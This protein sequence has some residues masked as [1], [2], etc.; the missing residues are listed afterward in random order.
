MNDMMPGLPDPASTE[1]TATHQMTSFC[2]SRRLTRDIAYERIDWSPSS[3]L[4]RFIP[5]RTKNISTPIQA[6]FKYGISTWRATMLR[7]PA[8]CKRFKYRDRR[9]DAAGFR[10]DMFPLRSGY[11]W[12][13]LSGSSAR[14][15][16]S[17]L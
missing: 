4:A 14:F 9:R 8:I 11:T 6:E 10:A 17:R 12:A 13:V 15:T 3:T 7:A 1:T 5:A 16:L 2:R